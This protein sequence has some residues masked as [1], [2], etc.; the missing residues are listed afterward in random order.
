MVFDTSKKTC[1][2]VRNPFGDWGDRPG[3][4]NA[5][6]QPPAVNGKFYILPNNRP[7]DKKFLRVHIFDPSVGFASLKE[8][9]SPK[10]IADHDE[11]HSCLSSESRVM[12][13][14]IIF[15]CH[16][17]EKNF[18]YIDTEKETMEVAFKSNL[19]QHRVWNVVGHHV[20]VVPPSG[21]IFEIWDA[22]TDQKSDFTWPKAQPP[23]SRT[24]VS[25][26]KLYVSPWTGTTMAI[27]G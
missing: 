18:Y 12:G 11:C 23:Y 3:D 25:N 13:R 26:N 1:T 6:R 15:Q 10:T 19:G 16:K 2:S 14:K 4:F 9:S 21:N 22:R 27:I 24:A 5:E 7:Y 8:V 17:F 20:I